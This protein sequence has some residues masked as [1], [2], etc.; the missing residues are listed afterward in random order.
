MTD[1]RTKEL[2]LIAAKFIRLHAVEREMFYDGAV[3]DGYCLAGELE[4]E[5]KDE[6]EP[7]PQYTRLG[8]LNQ[9]DNRNRPTGFTNDHKPINSP[10]SRTLAAD[11]SDRCEAEDSSQTVTKSA[12][13]VTPQEDNS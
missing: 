11:T 12:G 13:E 4:N 2:L 10:V 9:L 7:E 5:A 3:C 6:M 1:A 8:D